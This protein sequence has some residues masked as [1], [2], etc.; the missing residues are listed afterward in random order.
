MRATCDVSNDSHVDL[1]VIIHYRPT[2]QYR[3]YFKGI[4]Q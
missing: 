1:N 4:V 2:N 3:L